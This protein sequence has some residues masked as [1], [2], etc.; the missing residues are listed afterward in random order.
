MQEI[1]EVKKDIKYVS[2]NSIFDKS[3]LVS[4]NKV[5]SEQILWMRGYNI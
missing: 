2:L 4:I 5:R 3:S 1:Q